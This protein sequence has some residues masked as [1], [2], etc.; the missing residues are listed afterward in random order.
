MHQECVDFLQGYLLSTTIQIYD[1]LGPHLWT[2]TRSL[3]SQGEHVW[4]ILS[5][6]REIN[7]TRMSL[8]L[9]NLCFPT[10]WDTAISGRA[11]ETPMVLAI[12]KTYVLV[13]SPGSSFIPDICTLSRWL[14]FSAV[15]ALR[16][17]SAIWLRRSESSSL[18]VS[19]CIWSKATL[20]DTWNNRANSVINHWCI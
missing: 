7:F 17:S 12:F 19:F 3:C 2:H 13:T 10:R 1:E 5:H 14:Y 15:S 16:W 9:E 20:A 11:I 18:S 8:G 6:V 4:R